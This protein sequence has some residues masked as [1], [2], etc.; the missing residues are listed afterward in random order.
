MTKR[1]GS[2]FSFSR[3]AIVDVAAMVVFASASVLAA[4]AKVV[5]KAGVS[6]LESN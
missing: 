3:L 2:I 4:D 6:V 1:F 5:R